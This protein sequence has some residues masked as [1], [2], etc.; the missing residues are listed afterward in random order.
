[1]SLSEPSGLL[2]PGR[3]PDR[4][5]RDRLWRR[6]GAGS[7]GSERRSDNR[8]GTL[9]RHF[10]QAK[11]QHDLP[12][13]SDP[14]AFASFFA[15]GVYGMAVLASGGASRRD[16]D[17]VIRAAMK[18]RPAKVEARSSPRGHA[19]KSLSG[20]RTGTALST[21]FAGNGLKT[22]VQC[23]KIEM[24]SWSGS[25]LVKQAAAYWRKRTRF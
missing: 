23:P 18:A 9:G 21:L 24:R 1:M 13:D 11:S 22:V 12:K 6:S 16:L 17:Q 20:F 3:L 25:G 8:G 5:W 4:Q 10:E 15:A 14:A 7:L 19:S 2:R